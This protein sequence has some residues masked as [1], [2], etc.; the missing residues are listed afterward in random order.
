MTSLSLFLSDTH[1]RKKGGRRAKFLFPK[2]CRQQTPYYHCVVETSSELSD[3]FILKSILSVLFCNWLEF[4]CN[5]QTRQNILDVSSELKLNSITKMNATSSTG[6]TTRPSYRICSTGSSGS[7]SSARNATT[8]KR[9]S[10][11]IPN[12]GWLEHLAGMTFVSL[13]WYRI[14]K[15]TQNNGLHWNYRTFPLPIRCVEK[16]GNFK[17]IR[18]FC[19]HRV[20][21]ISS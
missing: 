17:S 19:V 7:S 15:S 8:R 4:I 2:V 16:R 18:F 9:I 3:S 13:F 10:R 20:G 11:S 6:P 14:H 12:A 21:L 1:V 5:F